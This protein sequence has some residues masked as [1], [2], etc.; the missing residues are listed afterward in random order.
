MPGYSLYDPP[1]D[2]LISGTLI[3][4]LLAG[5]NRPAQLLVGAP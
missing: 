4:V 2:G 3:D 5:D 1:V